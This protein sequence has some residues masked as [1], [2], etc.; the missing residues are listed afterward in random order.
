MWIKEVN[1]LYIFSVSKEIN[2]VVRKKKNAVE[3]SVF[4]FKLA[5][6]KSV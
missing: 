6:E 4:F 1:S 5:K 2:A 3:F